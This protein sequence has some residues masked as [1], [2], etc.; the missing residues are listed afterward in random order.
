MSICLGLKLSKHF[1]SNV[2]NHFESRSEYQ[3]LG[4][5]VEPK[6]S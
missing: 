4:L 1:N 2:C 3:I 5:I 6:K